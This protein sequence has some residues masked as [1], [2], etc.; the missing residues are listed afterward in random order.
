MKRLTLFLILVFLVSCT[1]SLKNTISINPI[2]APTKEEKTEADYYKSESNPKVRVGIISDARN[3]KIVAKMDGKSYEEAQDST[4]IIQ[5]GIEK[6]FAESDYNVTLFNAP[7][8]TGELEN[9]IVTIEPK[10]FYNKVEAKADI[11]LLLLNAK[12]RV[13]YRSKYSGVYGESG[14][15]FS[16]SDIEKTLTYAMHYALIEA[17]KDAR[18]RELI[19]KNQVND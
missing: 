19:S 10:T 7:T 13:I 12:G 2:S 1:P 8:I 6:Y 15:F 14:M 4:K 11:I 3:F 16:E 18:L 9:W 5:M 17:S